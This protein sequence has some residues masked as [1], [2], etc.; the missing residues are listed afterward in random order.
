MID[1]IVQEFLWLGDFSRGEADQFLDGLLGKGVPTPAERKDVYD[2]VG[3]R[4]AMLQNL[5]Q[6]ADAK[7][8]DPTLTPA[9]WLY[10]E[11]V[12][13]AEEEVNRFM[14]LDHASGPEDVIPDIPRAKRVQLLKD[15]A[16]GKGKYYA[17]EHQPLF[18]FS[19]VCSTF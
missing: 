15:L 4:P 8:A 5:K 16:R 17:L 2:V 18:K 9:T 11:A 1:F 12:P 19:Y 14:S 6:F 3:T 7:R 13:G 10:G